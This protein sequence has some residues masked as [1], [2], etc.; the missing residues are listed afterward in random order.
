MTNQEQCKAFLETRKT[1]VLSTQGQSGALETSV[2]PCVLVDG[3]IYIFISELAVHTQNLLWMLEQNKERS[4]EGSI[5]ASGL[6]V[7]DESETEQMFARERITLQ[8]VPTEVFAD[9]SLYQSVLQKMTLQFGDVMNMLTSLPDF[10][11]IELKPIQGGYVKGFGQAFAFEGG[12]CDLL[13]PIT[14]K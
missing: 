1:L 14:K 7:A 13:T 12:I 4:I 5:L 9:D 8:L 2:A 6:F 10:H 11:L 3:N